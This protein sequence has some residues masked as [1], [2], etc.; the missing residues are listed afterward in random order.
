M[1]EEK[2]TYDM[3]EHVFM[4]ATAARS[5]E[6]KRCLSDR[7]CWLEQ[8][9]SLLIGFIKVGCLFLAFKACAYLALVIGGISPAGYPDLVACLDTAMLLLVG[10]VIPFNPRGL[11]FRNVFA[12]RAGEAFDAAADAAFNEIRRPEQR[13]IE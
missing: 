6:M 4:I 10:L 11:F 8:G 3:A 2:P 9:V 12:A 7:Q 1:V 5:A 13:G